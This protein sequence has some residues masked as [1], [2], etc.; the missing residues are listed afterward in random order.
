[1]RIVWIFILI[2]SVL[3]IISTLIIKKNVD[4]FKTIVEAEIIEDTEDA[5]SNDEIDEKES[6][7]KTSKNRKQTPKKN[8]KSNSK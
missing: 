4:E 8:K 7:K 1:M 3:D 5:T 2:Y 6:S